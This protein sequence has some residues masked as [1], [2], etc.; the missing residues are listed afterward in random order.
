MQHYFL[1]LAGK[2]MH[3]L[4]DERRLIQEHSEETL[5]FLKVFRLYGHEDLARAK[6]PNLCKVANVRK[7]KLDNSFR[8][9]NLPKSHYLD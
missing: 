4:A 3:F 2:S 9:T 8:A 1:E 5:P 6:F 7:W